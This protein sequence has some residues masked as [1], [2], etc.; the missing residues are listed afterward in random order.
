MQSIYG[1]RNARVELFLRAWEGCGTA[2]AQNLQLQR[3]F[4]RA[5]R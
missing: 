5:D 1:W 3:N 4:A 2:A